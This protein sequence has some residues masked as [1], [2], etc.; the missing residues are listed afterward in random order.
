MNKHLEDDIQEEYFRLCAMLKIFAFAIP[1]GGKRN[2]REGARLKKQGVL[3]GVADVF[4]PSTCYQ[5]DKGLFIEFKAPKGVWSASQK[6]F[7]AQIITQKYDYFVFRD[8][9]TAINY[10]LAFLDRK[11]RI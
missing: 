6:D 9:I 5:T 3:A 10:T 2:A 8:A 1:N 4:V 7:S 11:E